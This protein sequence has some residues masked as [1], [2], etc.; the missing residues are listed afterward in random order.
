MRILTLRAYGTLA[1]WSGR[2]VGAMIGFFFALFS[3]SW[4]DPLSN[5]CGKAN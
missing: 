5:T 2:H 4:S 3:K 1:P